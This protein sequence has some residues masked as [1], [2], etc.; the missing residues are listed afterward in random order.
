MSDAEQQKTREEVHEAAAK[1]LASSADR[2]QRQHSK[3][4]KWLRLPPLSP[5]LE[6][7]QLGEY[8]K[9]A[10]VLVAYESGR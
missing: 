3:N 7:N 6:R 9:E 10:I 2:M 5:V 4:S 1:N 8:S